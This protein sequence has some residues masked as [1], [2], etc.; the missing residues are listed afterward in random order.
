MA[1]L[2]NVRISLK[3]VPIPYFIQYPSQGSVAVDIFSQN[4]SPKLF[5][6]GLAILSSPNMESGVL[7][8]KH[9]SFVPFV[10]KYAMIAAVI[11]FSL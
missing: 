8:F 2:A 5:C 3:G 11:D 9:N 4:I 6:R 7:T 10:S 1:S